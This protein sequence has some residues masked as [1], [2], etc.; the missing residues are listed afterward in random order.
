M[1]NSGIQF[2]ENHKFLRRKFH[3]C[4]GKVLYFAK[5]QREKEIPQISSAVNTRD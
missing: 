2:K 1:V 5:E 3:S 4:R